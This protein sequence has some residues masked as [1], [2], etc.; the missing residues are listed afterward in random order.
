MLSW[1]PL[2]SHVISQ[3]TTYDITSDITCVSTFFYL[4]NQLWWWRNLWYLMCLSFFNLFVDMLYFLQRQLHLLL[5]LS[6]DEAVFCTGLIQIYIKISLVIHICIS[7][8][9]ITGDTHIWYFSLTH[10]SKHLVCIHVYKAFFS[11]FQPNVNI[12]KDNQKLVTVTIKNT[13]KE[14]IFMYILINN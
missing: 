7:I 1:A 14:I 9:N 4:L 3:V 11:E 6:F 12:K 8:S 10:F 13:P 2:I 5:I